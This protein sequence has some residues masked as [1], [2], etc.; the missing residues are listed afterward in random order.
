[1]IKEKVKSLIWSLGWEIKKRNREVRENENLWL[2]NLGIETVLDIGANDGEFAKHVRSVL[3]TAQIYSFEPLKDCFQRLQA[4]FVEDSKFQA[5]NLALGS[6][7]EHVTIYR[8][9]YSPSSSLLPMAD[10]HKQAFPHTSGQSEEIVEV[11]KLDDL[12]TKL[13]IKLPLLLKMDVQG[14]ETEVIAGG[15]DTL[16]QA[17]VLILEMSL[18]K[19]YEGQELFDSMYRR[20]HDLG[21]HYCGNYAQLRHSEDNRVLQIDAIFRKDKKIL[22]S[23]HITL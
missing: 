12:A 22:D 3:P 6:Q 17:S 16:K 5:I 20:L 18:E 23:E 10:L 2:Q 9:S 7:A 4:H 11:A 8:S 14:F 1:M 13:N 19:L 21:F 15:L